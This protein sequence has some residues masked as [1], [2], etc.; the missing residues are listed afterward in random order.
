[1][2]LTVLGPPK[3]TVPINPTTLSSNVAT[4]P[5]D[6]IPC[7]PGMPVAQL[8]LAPVFV[9]HLLSA[10][11]FLQAPLPVGT[12]EAATTRSTSPAVA[13]LNWYECSPEAL[14]VPTVQLPTPPV[15]PPV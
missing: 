1:M 3:S 8:L 9:V 10:V 13:V 6:E 5:A 2:P 15:K 11:P 14:F 12:E 7:V 4:S